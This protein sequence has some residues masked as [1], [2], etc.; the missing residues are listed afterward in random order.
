MFILSVAHPPC[1]KPYEGK[2]GHLSQYW[3]GDWHTCLCC[4]N[5][6]AFSEERSV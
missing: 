2:I 5:E 6:W 4:L 3:N 1:V